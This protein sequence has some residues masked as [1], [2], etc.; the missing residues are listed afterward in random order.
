LTNAEERRL[1]LG[2]LRKLEI[3]S[4]IEAA[5]LV[6]LVGVAVPLKH[7]AHLN[8]AVKIMG[9]VHGVAFLSYVWTALQTVIG[10]GWRPAAIARLFLVAF[11][12]FA[13][14]ANLPFLR[15]RAAELH[16]CGLPK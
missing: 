12:P 7:L 5:T 8:L 2:Q 16:G 15:A 1:E 3:M 10:G 6:L 9:P 13:G 11:I 4:L 14:F